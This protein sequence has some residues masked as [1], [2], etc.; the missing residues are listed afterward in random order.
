MSALI[1]DYVRVL[2]WP[3][4]VVILAFRYWSVLQAL[5]P[6]SRIKLSISG[7]Q[8]EISPPELKRS[9]EESLRGRKLSK[10]QWQWLRKL[11]DEGRSRY[12][13]A[14]YLELRPLRNVGL[15]REHPEG[16]LTDAKEIEIT[17]LGRLL[18]DAHD[19]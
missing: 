12:D 15:I 7:V 14:T 8:V 19:Q 6:G 17:H 1:L 11:R 10:D 5:M 3:I 9:V 4:V 13:H 18:I 16:T 2:V